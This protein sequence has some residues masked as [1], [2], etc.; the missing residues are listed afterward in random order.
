MWLSGDLEQGHSFIQLHVDTC[1]KF[2]S[3]CYLAQFHMSEFVDLFM[4]S[5]KCNLFGFVI[6]AIDT[7]GYLLFLYKGSI[8]SY[9]FEVSVW[10]SQ[11]ER[12]HCIGPKC[13]YRIVF[14]E[15]LYS[16]ITQGKYLNVQEKSS[17]EKTKG[18]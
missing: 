1:L 13:I 5:K 12:L 2:F 16:I 6:K 9:K 3:Q 4:H 10:F 8:K 15:L 11:G 14:H 7:N 18:I 17:V